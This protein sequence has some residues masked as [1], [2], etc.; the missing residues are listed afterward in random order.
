MARRRGAGAGIIGVPAV[1]QH[2][3]GDR[4]DEHRIADPARHRRP[5]ECDR[6]HQ[7]R[8]QP[9]PEDRHRGAGD[10]DAHQPVVERRAAPHRRHHAERHAD[11][12]GEQDGADRQ[13]HRRRE[14]LQELAPHRVLRH[15]R[16]AEIAARHLLLVVQELPPH[17]L[18]EAELMAQFGQ[19]LGRDA[20][21][22]GARLDRIA[23]HQV[24][25]QEAEERDRDEGRH[26]HADRRMRKRSIT[27][28]VMR[29]ADHAAPAGATGSPA[30]R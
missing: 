4:L 20:A 23:G 16:G 19:P 6:E 22:A 7:D 1:D 11:Q 14:Q 15:D 9:P 27:V 21:L 26:D 8:H 2:E 25:Q 3:A 29:G 10:R 28:A 12:H 18:V 17:R 13:L 30:A 5:A 24:D